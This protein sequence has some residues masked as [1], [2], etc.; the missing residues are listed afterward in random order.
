MLHDVSLRDYNT[1]GIAAVAAGFCVVRDVEELAGLASV[2]NKYVLGGGSNVLLPSRLEGVLIKNE[3][4]G[5]A[6]IAEDADYV[7]LEVASGE[8]WH[9]FVLFALEHG[10]YGIEN[11]ALIPG[12][13]GAAPIQNIGA[14]GV[15]SKDVIEWVAYFR[16]D[17]QKIYRLSNEECR[18]G[19]RD[20]IFKQELSGK[21]M[22]VSVGFR[23]CK[24]VRLNTS[25]GAIET[26][27]ERMGVPNPTPLD[28][29]HAVMHIRR[30]KLPDPSLI[31]N[32]GSFFKNPTISVQQY[33]ELKSRF[34]DMPSY[35]VDEHS[36]KV[37]AGWLI[38]YCGWK[39]F[40]EGD[41]GVHERQSL[42]LVNYGT[43]TS[44][45]IWALSERVVQSVWSTFGILPEREVQVW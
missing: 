18:F 31:G 17:D 21:G 35:P 27:L 32:A 42:V 4:T 10:W 9:E 8:N 19:Y 1:F 37:P 6:L 39:G 7:H 11:L 43:A 2:P 40:R 44:K 36:V 30:S 15:E 5:K 16:W 23:L 28:V 3:L 38:E 12:T 14:Y 41:A 22:I 24:Q 26:E 33:Q 13:V 34:P 25:Y 29:A 45:D 20:S